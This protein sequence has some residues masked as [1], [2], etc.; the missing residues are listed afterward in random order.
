MSVELGQM[1]VSKMALI[2]WFIGKA[3][4]GFTFNYEPID[5]HEVIWKISFS[6]NEQQQQDI[7]PSQ[8]PQIEPSLG[9]LVA[10][11]WQ[12]PSLGG[13]KINCD[14]SFDKG[15]SRASAPTTLHDSTRHLVYGVVSSY[16]ATSAFLAEV[17]AVCLAWSLAQKHNLQL[18]NIE[19][20]N[21]AII[22]LC[23][24]RMCPLGNFWRW[25]LISKICQELNT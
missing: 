4:N 9:S 20:D 18:V 15:R 22:N 24:L 23:V 3:R 6:W 10:Q 7:N 14:A 19:S 11:R 1:F 17:Y 2:G 25:Y 21:Q 13:F 12:P 16:S 8:I 5:P